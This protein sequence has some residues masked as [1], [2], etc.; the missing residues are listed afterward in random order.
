MFIMEII[1][2]F[3]KWECHNTLQV[4]AVKIHELLPYGR[5][6]DEAKVMDMFIKTLLYGYRHPTSSP[7]LSNGTPLTSAYTAVSSS[8]SSNTLYSNTSSASTARTSFSYS[9]S[10]SLSI[11]SAPTSDH[12]TSTSAAPTFKKAPHSDAD[13][14]AKA[15]EENQ[16]RNSDDSSQCVV[17]LQ[18]WLSSALYPTQ[19]T[20]HL[21]ALQYLIERQLATLPALKRLNLG[22]TEYSMPPHG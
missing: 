15:L 8:T 16:S 17:A 10:S 13:M 2:S 1:T 11:S 14:E 5:G 22:Y 21:V 4:F 18:E 6:T 7:P 20:G 3:S 12:V 19:T 9:S